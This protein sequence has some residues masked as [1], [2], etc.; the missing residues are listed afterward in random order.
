MTWIWQL[1]TDVVSGDRDP[2]HVYET[3]GHRDVSLTYSDGGRNYTT[4]K[5]VNVHMMPLFVD[6]AIGNAGDLYNYTYELSKLSLV[7]DISSLYETFEHHWPLL[8]NGND[9]IGTEDLSIELNIDG[10]VDNDPYLTTELTLP[11]TGAGWYGYWALIDDV[12]EFVQ[13]YTE[14]QGTKILTGFTA[15]SDVFYRTTALSEEEY[16]LLTNVTENFY[17]QYVV[18]VPDVTVKWFYKYHLDVDWIFAGE[19]DPYVL[20]IRGSAPGFYDIKMVVSNYDQMVTTY[21]YNAFK[22]NASIVTVAFNSDYVYGADNYSPLLVNFYPRTTG[23]VTDYEWD[24]GDGTTRLITKDPR[25]NDVNIFHTYDIGDSGV[26]IPFTISLTGSNADSSETYTRDNYITVY[27]QPPTAMFIIDGPSKG[28]YELWVQF[29]NLSSRLRNCVWDFGDGLVSTDP[30]PLHHYEGIGSY[31]VTL[32][33]YNDSGY[34]IYTVE[35]AVTI[36]GGELPILIKD[37]WSF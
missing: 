8:E 10:R 27:P 15:I 30:E 11:I 37:T 33:V 24:L 7:S 34:S 20:N 28:P 9:I 17:I 29:N 19:G 26:K 36:T 21:K 12:W 14:T 6:I 25:D 22:L 31:T 1:D 13:F 35:N 23:Y 16:D 2:R 32:S 5:E 4:Y 3:I 18:D